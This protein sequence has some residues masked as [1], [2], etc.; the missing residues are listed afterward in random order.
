MPLL[1]G[2]ETVTITLRAAAGYIVGSPSVATVTI[3]SDDV[4]PDLTV[5]ALTAPAKAAPGGTIA[6]TDTTRNQGTSAGAASQTSLLSLARRVPRR[7]RLAA[8]QPARRSAGG[9]RRVDSHGAPDPARATRD[10]HLLPVRQGGRTGTAHRGERNEQPPRRGDFYRARSA[11]HQFHRA[12]RGVG[13]EHHRRQRY[14]HEPGVRARACVDH[15][16][17]SLV[18]CRVRCGR[19][20]CSQLAQRRRHCRQ[21][22]RRQRAR[23]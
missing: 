17:L 16:V 7:R 11:R 14:H 9:R 22:A 2:N 8:R 12:R 5:S 1:E 21:A 4:A 3:T 19:R 20:R 18:Q 15:V 6:V 23:R 13:R 10:R